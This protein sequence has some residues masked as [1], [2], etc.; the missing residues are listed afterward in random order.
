MELDERALWTMS[1]G[2]YVVTARAGGQ[3]NGQI[4]NTVF[5]VS[6]QPPRVAVAI[7]K[8]NFTHGLIRTSGFFAFSVLADSVPMERIGLFGFNSGRDVDKLAQVGMRSGL[9]C[10][11]VTDH[12]LAVAEVKVTNEVDAGTHTLFVGDVLAAEVL[13]A[14]PPLTY[15]GYHARKGRAPKTAPTYRGEAGEQAAAP[16]PGGATFSCGVCGHTYDPALGD[17][18]HGIAPG[19]RFADLPADWVC[20]VC[21]APREAF[22]P[23]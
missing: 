2:M 5:Q 13:A 9:H 14:G 6:A 11:L 8:E 20:P 3:A 21:G 4:A 1:Y 18:E 12:A 19:T 10:P 7:N 16:A 22:E 15:E 23:D 17:P